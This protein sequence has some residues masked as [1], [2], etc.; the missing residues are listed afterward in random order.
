MLTTAGPYKL[1]ILWVGRWVSSTAVHPD[2]K[3]LTE[4]TFSATCK[5]EGLVIYAK[6]CPRCCNVSLAKVASKTLGASLFLHSV[7][8][9]L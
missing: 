7:I 4:G 3:Q 9:T 2:A 1:F 6:P 8:S 5:A